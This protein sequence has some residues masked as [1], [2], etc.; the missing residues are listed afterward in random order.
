MDETPLQPVDHDKLVRLQRQHQALYIVARELRHY[1]TDLNCA[2]RDITETASHTLD[3]ERVS[4]WRYDH[5]QHTVSCAELY[6][7]TP[8]SHTGGAKLSAKQYPAYFR[9]METEEIIHASDAM[10]DSRTCELAESYLK[11][12][13][14]GS[15]LDAPI[16]AGSKL[17]GVLCHEHVGGPR[18]FYEDE[19]STAT[20]LADLV[21]AAIEHLESL[22]K[23]Q[24]IEVLLRDEVT[25]WNIL[26]E[27]SIDGIVILEQDGSVYRMNKRFMEMLG[28]T[29]EQAY[30]M[31]VWEWDC[32]LSKEDIIE[33]PWTVKESGAHYETKLR[34]KDGTLIDVEVSIN[35]AEYMGKKLAFSIVKDITDRKKVEMELLASEARY[36]TIFETV[37]D[38]I[39]TLTQDGLISSLNSSFERITGWLPEEWIGKP[40]LPIVHPDEQP[41]IQDNFERLLL[42][43]SVASVEVR[44]LTKSGSYIDFETNPTVSNNNGQSTVFGV[45]RDITERKQAEEQIRCF[46]TF[47]SLTGILNRREFTGIVENEIE[48]VRRY[49]MP[50]SLIMYDLDHFKWVNDTFGHNVG[51][52]VLQTVVRVVNKNMRSTD[53][54]GRWG[55]EE[56]MVLLLQT[57][58]DSAMKVAEGLRQAIEL[59]T[60]DKVGQLTASF[61]LTQL[62]PEDNIDSLTKRVDEALYQAKQRGRNRV[63]VRLA[64]TAHS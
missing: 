2:L 19:I 63:E 15:M 18:T 36:R 30:T 38:I 46:A 10:T 52:D 57:D 60:F 28:C 45:L 26:F 13:N 35:G 59:C 4:I 24:R 25:L 34:S 17:V 21:G 49:G 29:M 31:K 50:F 54:A 51:D 16:H 27:Q 7:A 6:E 44:V 47:D 20:L 8:N 55:G 33:R 53:V 41:L 9:A 62:V 11:P 23:N 39:F 58:L 42:G 61:G 37:E 32:Q 40:F 64:D 1:Q 22:G 14:I 43:E 3:I 56:F 5:Q 12:Q 48:R